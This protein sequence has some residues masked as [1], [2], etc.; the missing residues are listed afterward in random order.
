MNSCDEVR[1]WLSAYLDGE[2]TARRREAVEAHLAGCDACRRELASLR[3]VSACLQAWP[4]PEPAS[5]LSARFT[6]RLAARAAQQDRRPWFAGPWPRAAAATALAACLLLVVF[7]NQL[8]ETPHRPPV[9]STPLQNA[10]AGH[11]PDT[12]AGKGSDVA[13]KGDTSGD[14][15]TP[16]I[17][18]TDTRSNRPAAPAHPAAGQHRPPCP[19]V[20]KGPEPAVNKDT[21]KVPAVDAVLTAVNALN[22]TAVVDGTVVALS[23]HFSISDETLE[24][25]EA[26]SKT[27]NMLETSLMIETS[28]EHQPELLAIALITEAP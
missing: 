21:A 22:E 2:L 24:H 13:A 15:A 25:N 8:K 9:R 11:G 23:D 6:E 19:V 10:A 16:A 4:A 28:Y 12:T 14:S 7:I 17:N 26:M 5:D 1:D 18:V 3:Q 20:A 27:G